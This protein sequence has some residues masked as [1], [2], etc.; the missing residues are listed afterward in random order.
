MYV[1]MLAGLSWEPTTWPCIAYVICMYVRGLQSTELGDF[2][3]VHLLAYS[4]FTIPDNVTIVDPAVLG[5]IFATAQSAKQFYNA[6]KELFPV[7][8]LGGK[9]KC[10]WSPVVCLMADCCRVMYHAGSMTMQ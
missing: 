2:D 7:K 10:K 5:G 9:V 3:D 6:S 1:V 8:V 4:K